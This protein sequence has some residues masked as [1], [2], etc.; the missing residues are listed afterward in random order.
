[1]SIICK[2]KLAIPWSYS[3]NAN[4]RKL[5]AFPSVLKVLY[6]WREWH[7]SL[8]AESR[9][10]LPFTLRYL[11]LFS[12]GKVKG[13]VKRDS[14]SR[15]MTYVGEWPSCTS[16]WANKRLHCLVWLSIAQKNRPKTTITKKILL[17]KKL[18]NKIKTNRPQLSNFFAIIL[19]TRYYNNSRVNRF[20]AKN[21]RIF[22]LYVRS[23]SCYSF[24]CIYLWLFTKLLWYS[25][26]IIHFA[27]NE[28]MP[29]DREQIRPDTGYISIDRENLIFF[30]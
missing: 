23:S 19:V 8:L 24:S 9:F 17:S 16:W 21:S 20:D 22:K 1:M 10:T 14:A 30:S 15:E 2:M 6:L 5:F 18:S 13:N 29:A 11:L 28:W 25:C 4:S 3:L 27:C 12:I 26:V 7:V